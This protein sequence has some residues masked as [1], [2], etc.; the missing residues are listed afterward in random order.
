[1]KNPQLFETQSSNKQ[2]TRSRNS[3]RF[4]YKLI[5]NKKNFLNKIFFLNIFY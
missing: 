4:G 2:K 1:M 5:L 3:F